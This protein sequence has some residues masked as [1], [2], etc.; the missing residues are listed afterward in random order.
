[1]AGGLIGRGD[2]EDVPELSEINV[3]PFI[4]VMLV[5]LI[6]FMVAAPL[7]TVDVNVDLPASNAASAPRPD[8]PVYVTVQPDL[9]LLVGDRPVAAEALGPALAEVTGGDPEA[10]IFLRADRTVEYGALMAVM[11]SLRDSGH[12]RIALVGLEA[13]ASNAP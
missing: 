12:P 6:I 10:R 3:T 9:S 8:A 4:D 7:A 2:D 13:A 1:M 5:L 11:N